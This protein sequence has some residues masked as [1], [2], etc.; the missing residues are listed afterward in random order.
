MA[1]GIALEATATFTVYD[2]YAGRCL[3]SF[4]SISDF[5]TAD[6]STASDVDSGVSAEVE[7]GLDANGA[8]TTS[9]DGSSANCTPPA[10][11]DVLVPAKTV[12]V[13]T[14]GSCSASYDQASGEAILRDL[15]GTKCNL[16]AHTADGTDVAVTVNYPLCSHE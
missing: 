2:A 6:A 9:V 10:E 11:L 4:V 12:S 1:D 16:L 3:A 13:S 8:S 5:G 7:R 15:R 14:D